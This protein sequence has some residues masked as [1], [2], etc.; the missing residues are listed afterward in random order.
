VQSDD[1]LV[2]KLQEFKQIA[3][4]L[5]PV[6]AALGGVSQ[7]TVSSHLAT[8]AKREIGDCYI[9]GSWSDA[10]VGQQRGSGGHKHLWLM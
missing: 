1:K 3:A 10:E 5:Q 9:W 8:E 4:S 7:R 6:K 2:D